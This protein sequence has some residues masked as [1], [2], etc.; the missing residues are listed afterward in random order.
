M[1]KPTPEQQKLLE[2][3][4][5]I[6]QGLQAP[7]SI[8]PSMLGAAYQPTV[9]IRNQ[10]NLRGWPDTA[11]HLEALTKAFFPDAKVV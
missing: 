8:S 5:T 10:L 2:N 3:L 7:M 6:L 11:E 9:D 1:N 4:A